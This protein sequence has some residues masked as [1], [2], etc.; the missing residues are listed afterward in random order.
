MTWLVL[1]LLVVPASFLCMS[2]LDRAGASLN[3]I[4]LSLFG[5]SDGWRSET[6]S[7]GDGAIIDPATRLF[8]LHLVLG[9]SF[10]GTVRPVTS[11]KSA[12]VIRSW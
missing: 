11:L 4:S 12:C 5:K 8:A 6:F 2:E 9:V 3:A 1:A 10:R 7:H